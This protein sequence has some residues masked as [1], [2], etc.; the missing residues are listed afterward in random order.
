[1]KII[2]WIKEP[3]FYQIAVLYMSAQ[4]YININ[5]SFY[6]F[7]LEDTLH[8]SPKAVALIPLLMFL[9]G[10]VV[11]RLSGLL[12]AVADH[13][14]IFGTA[15]LVGLASCVWINFGS[16]QTLKEVGALQV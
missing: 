3:Q 10:F 11:S 4:L 5:Q 14:V 13:R 6:P 15:C 2:D 16:V 7:F 8:M 9:A 12:D 1:M